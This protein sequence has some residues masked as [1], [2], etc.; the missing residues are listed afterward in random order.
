MA[1]VGLSFV[2]VAGAGL[3][4]RTFTTLVTAPLGFDPERLL[5]V[6]VDA[7]R[8]NAISTNDFALAQR[9]ADAAARV[10]G[11]A[12]V[13]VSMMTPMSQ[14]NTPQRVKCPRAHVACARNDLVN[15]IA[16]RWSRPTH[17]TPRRA[18]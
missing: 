9:V 12:R 3:F 8:S 16:P 7:P 4:V 5:L 6:S 13:S 14:R 10:P 11:V 1:Q 15:A 17:A 18:R 2:L